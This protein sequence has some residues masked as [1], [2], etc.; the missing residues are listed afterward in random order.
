ML[1]KFKKLKVKNPHKI[2]GGSFVRRNHYTRYN[3]GVG[4]RTSN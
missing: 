1:E 3:A 4:G 2:K